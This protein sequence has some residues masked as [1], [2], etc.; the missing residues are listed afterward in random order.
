VVPGLALVLLWL[1]WL[2]GLALA[3]RWFRSQPQWVPLLAVGAAIFWFIYVQG[4]S[5]IFGWTA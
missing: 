4:G 2:A 1:V 3:I 5:Q